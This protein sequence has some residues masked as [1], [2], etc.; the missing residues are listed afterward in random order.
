M[1][2]VKWVIKMIEENIGTVCRGDCCIRKI[3]V[4]AGTP[5]PKRYVCT[6][7]HKTFDRFF[8]VT[9]GCF[10]IRNKS[11]IELTVRPGMILY[12]PTDVEYE[13][14]W[15][16]TA[17]GGFV[18]FNFMLF[19]SDGQ[20]LKLSDE[21]ELVA[22]DK[23]GELYHLFRRALEEY[24]RY[25]KFVEMMLQSYFYRIVHAIVRQ[26]ERKKLKQQ[27]D[28]RVIYKAMLYLNDHYMEESTTEQLAAIC[29]LSAATFRRI[30]KKYNNMSPLKYKN[31]LRMVHAQ[32]MLQSGFYTVS[33][34]ADLINCTD[35]S[36]FNKLYRGE[37]GINPSEDIRND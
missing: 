27:E 12:L 33:E 22:D 23:S 3:V 10:H 8:Y 28:A 21:V 35:L 5:N 20:P 32:E 14:Y 25:E 7:G 4:Y 36:H 9:K 17:E 16:E 31:H 1:L 13:S 26:D 19:D 18:S 15:D 24:L 30:F 2:L 34:V 29:G 11:G 6:V 37:F